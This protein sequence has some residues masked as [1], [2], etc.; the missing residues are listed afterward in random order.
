MVFAVA[1]LK[2]SVGRDLPIAAGAGAVGPMAARQKGVSAQQGLGAVLLETGLAGI[3]TEQVQQV[4]QVVV[5][6]IQTPGLG[7]KTSLQG[8]PMGLKPAFYLVQPMITFRQD[9]GEPEHAQFTWRQALPVA[10]R[11]EV[12][13]RQ[14][15]QLHVAHLFDQQRN[16][17]DAF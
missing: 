17:V 5:A 10:V 14:G 8:D 13:V 4:R 11:L 2:Q 16:I 12:L 9:V 7:R 6:G 1:E 3:V 15:D